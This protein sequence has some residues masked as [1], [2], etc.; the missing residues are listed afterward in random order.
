MEPLG[1]ETQVNQLTSGKQIHPDIASGPGGKFLVTWESDIRS[2][3]SD[4]RWSIRARLLD[5]NLG[6]AGPELQVNSYTSGYQAGSN[7]MSSSD[8]GFVVAWHSFGSPGPDV[9]SMTI[10]ARRFD[11]NVEPLGPEFQVNSDPGGEQVAP[12]IAAR[13]DGIHLILWS[14]Y[15]SCSAGPD[16]WCVSGRWF[17]SAWNPLGDDFQVNSLIA[18]SQGVAG[19]AFDAHGDVLVGWTSFGSLGGDTSGSSAQ[20]RWLTGLFRDGFE[21]GDF[22][23]WSSA[24]AL[25]GP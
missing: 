15:G 2:T 3:S 5:D 19:A 20:A 6:S 14:E 21:S 22:G 13:S 10:L 25:G 8:A 1:P 17:D 7:V 18:S 9:E 16:P 23:R 12:L 4:D 11:S 24:C